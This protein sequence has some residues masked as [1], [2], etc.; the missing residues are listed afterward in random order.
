MTR[1]PGSTAR[2]SAHPTLSREARSSDLSLHLRTPAERFWRRR[3]RR[4]RAVL[5]PNGEITLSDARKLNVGWVGVNATIM[6]TANADGS[7]LANGVVTI[8]TIH[9]GVS[10]L[11]DSI[12][13][14]QGDLLFRDVDDWDA[15]A[16]GTAGYVLVTGGAGANPSWQSA[17]TLGLTIGSGTSFPGSPYA[18]EP[19]YRTDSQRAL[20]VHR[21]RV[22]E[23]RL[24][25]AAERRLAHEHRG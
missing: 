23:R 21:Q 4:P 8:R 20:Y 16:P 1:G 22:G 18:G 24:A 2:L 17:T 5:H 7:Y 9:G 19:F 11:L 14:V 15:L 10:G 6:Q 3:D 12:G 13:A 25:R